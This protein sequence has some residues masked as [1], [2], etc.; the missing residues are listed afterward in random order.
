MTLK[1]LVPLPLVALRD[2]S[3]PP[4]KICKLIVDLED[5]AADSKITIKEVREIMLEHNTSV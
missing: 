5:L 2:F 3:D 1:L 4:P